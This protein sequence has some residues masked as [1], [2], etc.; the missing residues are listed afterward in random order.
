[1]KSG[2]MHDTYEQGCNPMFDKSLLM[3][4]SNEPYMAFAEEGAVIY[5]QPMSMPMQAPIYIPLQN[6]PKNYLTLSIFATICCCWC[7]G[8]FAVVRA[9]ESR[10]AATYGD[11]I[12]AELKSSEAKKY[13]IISIVL[14]IILMAVYIVLRVY[15]VP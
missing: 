15:F 6:P 12:S 4:S 10:S 8:V 2:D 13:S 5:S 3:S 1:M 7:A 11:R 14:G 9:V